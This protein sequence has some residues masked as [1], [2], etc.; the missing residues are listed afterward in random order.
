MWLTVSTMCSS[1]ISHPHNHHHRCHH[2]CYYYFSLHTY[3]SPPVEL[4]FFEIW[5]CLSKPSI[6]PQLRQ[7]PDT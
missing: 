5:N 1:L 2:Y 7:V 3:L 6:Y 4:C